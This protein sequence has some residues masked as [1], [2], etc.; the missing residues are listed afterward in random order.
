MEIWNIPR[1]FLRVS[2]NMY[3]SLTKDRATGV[4]Y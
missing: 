1:L 2:A 3:Y 4:Y